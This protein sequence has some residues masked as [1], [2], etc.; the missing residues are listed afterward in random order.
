M[1]MITREKRGA[2]T[3]LK[4]SANTWEIKMHLNS[5]TPALHWLCGAKVNYDVSNLFFGGEGEEIS[6]ILYSTEL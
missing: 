2:T 4:L 6:G 1:V 5:S 3:A